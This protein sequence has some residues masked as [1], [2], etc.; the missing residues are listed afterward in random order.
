M[1]VSFDKADGSLWLN[2]DVQPKADATSDADRA[3]KL[4]DPGFG[5]VFTDHMAIVRYSAG[6]GWHSA[7]VRSAPTSRSIRRPRCCTTPRKSSRG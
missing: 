7:R 2:F 3:D 6:K 4:K 1:G 5:R